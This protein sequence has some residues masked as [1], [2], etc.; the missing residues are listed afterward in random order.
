M[1]DIHD[2]TGILLEKGSDGISVAEQIKRLRQISKYLKREVPAVG[3]LVTLTR[4]LLYRGPLTKSELPMV[5]L[6]VIPDNAVLGDFANVRVGYIILDPE[7]G[8]F[9]HWRWI[10][11]WCLE[12]Y[13]KGQ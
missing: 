12:P 11:H 5:V 13:V 6:N 4:E 3:S 1:A 7:N 2:M 9:V 10:E 8:P